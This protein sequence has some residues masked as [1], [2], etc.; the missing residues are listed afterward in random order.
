[1]LLSS[2]KASSAPAADNT[3]IVFIL[4]DDLGITDIGHYARH[5]TGADAKDLFY[6]TPHLDKLAADGIAFSQSYSNQL[7]SPTR[8][9]ILTGRIASKIGFTT[10]TPNT[11]TWHNQGLEPPAG[12]NPHDVIE[13]KD[14]LDR[15][16]PW[17]NATTNT[18]LDPAIPTWPRV[19]K[20]H[21]SA[22]LGK[23]HLG[24]HGSAE[25]QPK[26]FGFEEIA[27]FDS[28]GSPYFN[29][30]AD[31]N[32]SKPH[33]PSM[34]GDFRIGMAGEQSGRD[35]LTDDQAF[36]AVRFIESRRDKTQPFLL[37]YAPFA[38]HTPF[39]A[40]DET[41]RHFSAKK[42]S[43][44]LGRVNATYAAM[45]KH[46]DDAVGEIRDALEKTGLAENTILIFTADDGGV[47]YTD[48]PATTN[49]PFKG[50]KACLYEG[51]IRVPTIIWQPGRFEGG[52]WCDAVIDCT[53]FLPTIAGL[54]ENPAPDDIDGMSI[55]PLL[56][57]PA[58]PWPQRTLVWHYPFNV[59][60]KHPENGEPLSPHSAI[61]VGPHKLIWDWHGRLSLYHIPDDPFEQNDLAGK[62][63]GL[64]AQL[65]Q[66]LKDWLTANVAPRY[67]P[68]LDEKVKPTEATRPFPFRDLR[69]TP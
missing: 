27:Y 34:R 11:R 42:Q 58:A 56:E 55:L 3:N 23:W 63:P 36:R 9:A 25:R 6:E 49:R 32:R 60:V 44:H 5:F 37:Y 45:L 57:N 46:L 50:G 18:A 20:N 62:Q 17:I 48:P 15:A 66:R 14:G 30:Q 64:T 68:R 29:W 19:L 67:W 12:H 7:C 61:R 47:E 54:T 28:G 69:G 38:V 51:G 8:A 59:A 31:W 33:F 10:A 26:A 4:A 43:G 35:Y 2:I 52:K 39:Q 13:H 24:G 53:D 21:H 22:Y 16:R 41:I 40:P 65:H 1:M